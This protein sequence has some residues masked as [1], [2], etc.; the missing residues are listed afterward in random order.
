[1]LYRTI[2]SDTDH[3]RLQGDLDKLT[4]WALAWG[5]QFHPAKCLVMNIS[6]KRHPSKFTYSLHNTDLKTTDTAKYMGN[7]TI[8]QDMKWTKHTTETCSRSHRALGFIKRNVKIRSPSIKE[9]LYSL[10][11]PHVEYASAIG[12]PR[13]VKPIHQ[14]EMVQR[15]AARWTLNRHHNTGSVKWM[16][17]DL[18]W[19]TLEQRHIDCRMVL[20]FQIIHGLVQ[21]PP[22]KYIQPSLNTTSR[23]NHNYTY[24]QC[25]TRTNYLKYSLFTYTT[26]V[27]N[28]LPYQLVSSP[29]VIS[30]KAQVSKLQHIRE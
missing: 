20:L 2:K 17:E 12:S 11:C 4:E 28:N 27:W 16:L 15:R 7:V 8:S 23:K 19:R 26:V 13:E 3:H 18:Q 5:M 30:F 22:T 14:L 10:V 24:Q 25:S 29:S 9:K 21:I 1:M 6:Q